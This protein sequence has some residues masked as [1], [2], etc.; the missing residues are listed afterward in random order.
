MSTKRAYLNKRQTERTHEGQN[1]RETI[2]RDIVCWWAPRSFVSRSVL[3]NNNCFQI[4]NKYLI[5][6]TLPITLWLVSYHV[7]CRPKCGCTTVHACME[8]MLFVAITSAFNIRCITICGALRGYL[9]VK[10]DSYN[11]LL[12]S[13]HTMSVIHSASGSVWN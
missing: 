11:N 1:V 7:S 9:A 8:S 12:L 3:L 13:V 4:N 5:R 6:L 10:L 2:L